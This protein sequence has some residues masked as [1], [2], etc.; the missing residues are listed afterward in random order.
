M[1]GFVDGG[2]PQGPGFPAQIRAAVQRL[3][4]RFDLLDVS[5]VGMSE[6]SS[7]YLTEALLREGYQL[8]VTGHVL[9]RALDG[10]SDELE[11]VTLVDY[12]GGNGLL[13]LLAREMG[14]GTIVFNDIFEGSCT[15]ARLLAK[16][17]GLEADHYVHGD[18]DALTSFLA[19]RDLSCDVV[20]SYDVIEHIYDVDEH[21]QHLPAITSGRLRVVMASAANMLNPRRHR[22]LMATQR[23]I[24]LQ[25]RQPSAGHKERDALLAYA[26]IRA[27]LIRAHAPAL[28]AADVERLTVATRG[29]MTGDIEAAVD[30][31]VADG[32]LPQPPVHPTNTCDPLTGNWAEHL[33]DPYRLAADLSAA[34][35]PCRVEAGYYAFNSGARGVA[36]AVLNRAVRVTG[37]LGLRMA[38][39]YV[40]VGQ[41]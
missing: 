36:G 4:T 19:E 14:V 23:L 21:L 38:P 32:M 15:D 33:M 22:Q 35:V 7:R 39:Y 18:L 2:L 28:S 8:N 3:K 29:L 41:R 11:S 10:L 13:S 6:Y 12:G 16:T 20:V 26:N 9:F 5:A 24:E 34:G 31:F 40:L 30:R 25:D 1:T 37:K 17:M 27:G